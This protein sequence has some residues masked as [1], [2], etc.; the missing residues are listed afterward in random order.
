MK[1]IVLFVVTIVFVSM[2][3]GQNLATPKGGV[4]SFLNQKAPEII[5]EKWIGEAQDL[6]GKFVILEFWGTTCGPCKAAIPH[7]NELNKGMKQ[8]NAVIVSLTSDSE[9]KIAKMKEPVI[10]DG[11]VVEWVKPVMNY[12]VAIDSKSLTRKA[13]ELIFIPHTL[14]IDPDGIVR[15]EGFPEKV[16]FELIDKIIEEYKSV[17]KK[18]EQVDVTQWGVKSYLNKKAPEL[19]V[20]TGE[21]EN[22]DT[23]GKFVLFE[24]YGL[25]CP[26]C[27]TAIPKLNKLHHEF[28]DDVVIMG[29]AGHKGR[30][31]QEPKADYYKGTDLKRTTYNTLG[32]KFVPYALLVDPK[33]IVRWEGDPNTLTAEFFKEMIKK[34][35]K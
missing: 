30:L 29:I 16:T 35:K 3:F 8:R 34:Y 14:I 28:K 19:V 31:P 25:V 10:K 21:T 27:W 20:E 22:P 12:P 26:P 23:K 11:K 4:K 24:M 9:E 17:V 13:L 7:L 5:I 33:G 15:W 6:R 1:K 32:L 18:T 2:A